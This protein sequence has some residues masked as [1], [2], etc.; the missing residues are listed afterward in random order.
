M[1]TY[2]LDVPNAPVPTTPIRRSGALG[3]LRARVLGVQAVSKKRKALA[4][5]IAVLA[6]LAQLVLWPAFA[7]GAASPIDD[8]LDA[9]VAIALLLTLGFS[10]RLA[11]ALALELV[12]GADLFPTWS[13]V[14]ASIPAVE[15]PAEARITQRA[16]A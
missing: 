5:T 1:R 6:D 10:G 16:P 2:A 8:A 14:V 4:L 12:P 9:V 15:E 11:L 13:A 7:A 3:L